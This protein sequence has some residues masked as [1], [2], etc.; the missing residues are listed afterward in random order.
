[1]FRTTICLVNLR[2]FNSWRLDGGGVGSTSAFDLIEF[3]LLDSCR[4]DGGGVG[5]TSTFDLIEFASPNI[6]W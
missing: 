5:R 1:M 3:A 6:V 4:L 2:Q